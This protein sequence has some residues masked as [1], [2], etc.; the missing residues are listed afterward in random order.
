[1]NRNLVFKLAG[2]M[3]VLALVIASVAFFT[4]FNQTSNTLSELEI[5]STH[6]AQV[7]ADF[8][9]NMRATESQIQF[10]LSESYERATESAASLSSELAEMASN[11]DALQVNATQVAGAM[12][13]T[14]T[15]AAQDLAAL[16]SAGELALSEARATQSAMVAEADTRATE[17]AMLQLELEAMITMAQADLDTLRAEA[18]AMAALFT[19]QDELI[20]TLRTRAEEQDT[21]VSELESEIDALAVQAAD[22]DSLAARIA[23]LENTLHYP[24]VSLN[25]QT[26]GWKS[27]EQIFQHFTLTIP[28]VYTTV[29]VAQNWSNAADAMELSGYYRW[30]APII[31]DN[32]GGNMEMIAYYSSDSLYEFFSL[33]TQVLPRWTLE[34]YS[35]QYEENMSSNF[36]LVQLNE[37]Q[38]QGGDGFRLILVEHDRLE[39]EYFRLVTYI[40]KIEDRFY[41]FEFCTTADIHYR[42]AMF[43]AIPISL[44]PIDSEIELQPTSLPA[45]S[46]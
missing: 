5:N 45:R 41:V 27:G 12:Q 7:A 2:S 32:E 22:R 30:W 8:A 6:S 14:A 37:F 39:S 25:G 36:E 13:A 10:T 42:L 18:Q 19:E 46:S 31:R 3:L 21:R 24:A 16:Q 44:K 29:D 34:F 28:Q 26:T 9:L 43:D 23:E 17:Q 11:R 20:D 4:L 35:R 15:S 1:M 40:L 38:F 33:Y